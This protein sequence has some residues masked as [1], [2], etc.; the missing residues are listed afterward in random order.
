MKKLLVLPLLLGFT[1]AVYAESVHLLV[2]RGN[3]S[4]Q[5]EMPSLEQCEYEGKRSIGSWKGYSSAKAGY[6]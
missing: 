2:K 3:S 1:S 4:F 6:I 5:L